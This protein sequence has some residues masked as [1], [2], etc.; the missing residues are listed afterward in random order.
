MKNIAYRVQ[1]IGY[2]VTKLLRNFVV[3]KLNPKPY[4]LNPQRGYSLVE[5]LVAITV[6]LI[7]LVGPLTIAQVGLQRAINSREQTMAVFL[8]QEGIEAVFKL[9]EEDA[10][11]AYPSSLS[12]LNEA[13]N[14]VPSLAGVCTAAAPCGVILGADGSVALSSFYL[15][16][17]NNCKMTFTDAARVPYRQGVTGGVATK[18][19]RKITITSSSDTSAIVKSTVT[20]GTRSDQKVTL[21]TY[22][23][24]IYYEPT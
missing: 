23:Y 5:V 10:L 6:L 19:E 14:A 3:F 18:F 15:C 11:A 22:V 4:S 9:R 16:D 24:N 1:G 7:A 21:E 20:W 8:A 12:I 17:A 2:R 13:W